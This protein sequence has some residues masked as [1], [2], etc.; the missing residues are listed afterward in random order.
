MT[1]WVRAEVAV[2]REGDGDGQEGERPRHWLLIIDY[3]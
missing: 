2:Q 3:W 1:D